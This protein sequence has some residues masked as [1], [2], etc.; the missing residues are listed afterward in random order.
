[1]SIH[2][3]TKA[4]TFI[5]RLGYES[6]MLDSIQEIAERNGVASATFSAIGAVKDATISFYDQMEKRYRDLRLDEPL[7]V[8]ACMGNIGRLGRETIVHGHITLSDAKGQAY[9]GHLMRGTTV[10]AMEVVMTELK[11]IELRREFDSVTGLNQ[12]KDLEDHTQI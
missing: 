6:D 3:A 12:I 9:G 1:M 8:L 11:G 2:P 4:R 10:F 7:E 5:C